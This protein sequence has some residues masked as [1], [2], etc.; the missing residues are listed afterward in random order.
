M[1]WKKVGSLSLSLLA[2]EIFPG[3]R[4]PKP[5]RTAKKQES[6]SE[7]SQATT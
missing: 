6:Q 2:F 4:F 3:S 5:S 1:K 7:W